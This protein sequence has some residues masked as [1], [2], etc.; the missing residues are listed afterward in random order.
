MKY[1]KRYGTHADTSDY[2]PD[3]H[4]REYVPTAYDDSSRH[5]DPING[6]MPNFELGGQSWVVNPANY[7]APEVGQQDE[8][9][10]KTWRDMPG[11]DSDNKKLNFVL[12]RRGLY[13]I[14]EDRKWAAKRSLSHHFRSAIIAGFI[15]LSSVACAEEPQKRDFRPLLPKQE[16]VGFREMKALPKRENTTDSENGLPANS[17]E[18]EN[19]LFPEFPTPSFK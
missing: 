18:P 7:H 12:F 4:E 1:L 11:T 10:G 17:S 5:Y 3:D 19:S 2:T 13:S 8:W 16:S 6:A 14:E 15:A 9:Q